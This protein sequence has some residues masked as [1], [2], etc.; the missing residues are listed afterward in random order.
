[1]TY[2]DSHKGRKQFRKGKE[3]ISLIQ[4]KEQQKIMESSMTK[5][6]ELKG[7][8]ETIIVEKYNS[9]DD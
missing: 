3:A 1:M 8:L 7:I 2:P 4:I 5:I 9:S 6:K